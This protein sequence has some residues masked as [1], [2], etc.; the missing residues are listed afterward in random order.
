M[1]SPQ[2]FYTLSAG[3]LYDLLLGSVSR[4][5]RK[6]AIHS[7]NPAKGEKLLIAGCGT[8][9]DFPHLP[10]NTSTFGFDLN[11]KMLHKAKERSGGTVSLCRADAHALPYKENAFD[12][13]YLFL[14]L[15]IIPKP[16]LFMQEVARVCRA[17]AKVVLVDKFISSEPSFLLNTFN[18]VTSRVATNINLNFNRLYQE[19]LSHDFELKENRDSA[20]FGYVRRITLLKKEHR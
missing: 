19:S 16:A 7:L 3:F 6:E 8:G 11:E 10:Q 1:K 17:S 18:A 12:A 2:F 15:S 14:I 9:L 13:A 20:L 4:N 5:L